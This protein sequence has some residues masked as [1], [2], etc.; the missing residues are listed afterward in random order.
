MGTDIHWILERQHPDRSWN[1]VASKTRVT[2][3]LIKR[4]NN[5]YRPTDHTLPEQRLGLRNYALFDALSG[6]QINRSLFDSQ[7]MEPGLP[8]DASTHSRDDLAQEDEIHSHGYCMLAKLE[9]TRAAAEDSLAPGRR[10]NSKNDTLAIA[11][12]DMADAVS[13][14]LQNPVQS[15]EILTGRI[16]DG[17]DSFPDMARESNH[18][19]LLRQKRY[20]QLLPT[21]THTVRLLVGY[22]N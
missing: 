2:S 16:W 7:I 13:A 15:G 9:L 8:E 19:A 21:G 4:N 17:N 10:A 11:L 6:Q 14:V 12:V 22:D 5:I 1:A 3:N 20:R 18:A